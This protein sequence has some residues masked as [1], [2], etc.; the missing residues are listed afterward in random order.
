MENTKEIY[1]ETLSMLDKIEEIYK[2]IE[3]CMAL[4]T[5][6]SYIQDVLGV[7]QRNLSTAKLKIQV[8]ND[9]VK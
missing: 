6:T 7:A 5:G 9:I 1:Y 8:A 3:T 2:S 4:S